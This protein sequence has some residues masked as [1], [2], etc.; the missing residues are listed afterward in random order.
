MIL[1]NHTKVKK[2]IKTTFCVFILCSLISCGG[3]VE[4]SSDQISMIVGTYTGTG[5]EGIYSLSFDQENGNFRMLDSLKAVN[6]S[7]LIF[8]SEENIIYTVNEVENDEAGL[9]AVGFDKSNG[10]LTLINGVATDSGA[11]CYIATNGN[12]VA[13]ANYGGGSLTLFPLAMDGRLLPRDTIIYGNIGGPDSTRQETPHVHCV[14]F[15]PD[16]NYLLATDFSADRLMV[17]KISDD[18][19]QL[20]C[21]ENENGDSYTV[22]VMSDYGPRHIIFDKTGKHAYVIGEL[23][24]MITLFDYQ[25]ET[26]VS[27]QVIDAD[28]YDG[29]GSADI[30]LSPDGQFLYAS[31]RLKGDG[32]SIFAVNPDSG[33]LSEIGYQL[34]GKHPRHFNITPN[35]KYLLVAC[36]D[37]DNI[38]IFLRNPE[39]GLLSDTGRR[40]NIPMPVCVQFAE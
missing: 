37:N 25:D 9:S 6:P 18:G 35:G 40:I 32:I 14:E 2:I 19:K 31:N 26:L 1:K 28:P 12:I 17:F 13:T 36:R 21:V 10:K 39:T 34:T 7:Y 11:P 38:E 8:N 30:H 33:E 22:P 27:K 5:S 29:R 23:S 24:G 3:K 4:Q 15:T 16:G 20:E